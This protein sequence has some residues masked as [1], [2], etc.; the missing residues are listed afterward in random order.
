MKINYKKNLKFVT[1]L[2]SALLIATVSAAAYVT[3]TWTTTATV[4]TYP[5][6]CFFAWSAPT[7][8]L[9]TFNYAVDIFPSIKTINVN[10]TYGIW[11]WDSPGQTVSMR[12]SSIT[13]QATNIQNVTTYV[14]D[15]TNT[16]KITVQFIDGGSLPTTWQ[17]F[18]AS[19]TTKYTLWT[20][21][22]AKST[23]SVSSVITYELKV[24][25]P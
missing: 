22:E 11:S 10:I 7:T 15:A 14:K 21:I 16:T 13:N 18:S 20:E 1:L 25:N 17:S 6:V 9:N 12:I 24:E 2:I 8:K 5:K 23:A 4:G 3:L 19:A